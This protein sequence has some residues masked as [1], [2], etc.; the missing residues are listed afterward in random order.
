MSSLPKGIKPGTPAPISGQVKETGSTTEKTV[1]KGNPM[2]PT[3]KPGQTYKF[4]DKTKHAPK[5]K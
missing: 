1:V 3:S 5:K 4:V 2:P